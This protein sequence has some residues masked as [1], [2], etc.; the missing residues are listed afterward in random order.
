MGGVTQR[1]K[2]IFGEGVKLD[3]GRFSWPGP[4]LVGGPVG[5]SIVQRSRTVLAQSK[6]FHGYPSGRRFFRRRIMGG[7]SV[8]IEVGTG[9][10]NFSL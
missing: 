1:M 2:P 4:P 3:Q 6:H 10:I 7:T 5:W 9:G 8:L